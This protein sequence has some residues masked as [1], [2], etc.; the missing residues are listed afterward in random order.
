M[1]ALWRVRGKRREVELRS[2]DHK[3]H[4]K[5]LARES[6]EGVLEVLLPRA[7]FAEGNVPGDEKVFSGA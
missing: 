7:M 1:S 2:C 6:G 4:E 3:R 5:Y